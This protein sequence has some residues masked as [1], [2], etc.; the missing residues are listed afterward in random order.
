A[1]ELLK[2]LQ[3][4][5]LVV[6]NGE[7][8]VYRTNLSAIRELFIAWLCKHQLG[9][10]TILVNATVHLTD[11]MPILP[12]MVRKTLPVLDAVA[13]RE[14]VSRRNLAQYAPDVAVGLIPDSAFALTSD[15]A[16][17]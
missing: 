12:A 3:G 11:V 9:I 14:P 8:S 13:V 10:S 17:E 16:L 15:D 4:A 2:R 1:R 6:L 7:G 5:D